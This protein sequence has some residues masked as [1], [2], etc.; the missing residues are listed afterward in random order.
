MS[1]DTEYQRKLLESLKRD[2]TTDIPQIMEDVFDTDGKLIREK[3]VFD[4]GFLNSYF[5]PETQRA[6]RGPSGH[7]IYRLLAKLNITDFI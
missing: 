7:I 2:K 3:D 1:S 4:S 5:S 6:T